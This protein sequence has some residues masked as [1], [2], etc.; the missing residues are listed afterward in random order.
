[1]TDRGDSLLSWPFVVLILGML[2]PLLVGS[3][4][5]CW[6]TD[7]ENCIFTDDPFGEE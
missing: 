4:A 3:I 7:G 1:M 5:E 2:T 6:F